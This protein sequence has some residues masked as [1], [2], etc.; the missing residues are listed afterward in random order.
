MA[1]ATAPQASEAAE[2]IDGTLVAGEVWHIVLRRPAKRNALTL[3]MFT[4]LA[5]SLA[6]ADAHPA[7]RAIALTGEG[8]GFCAGHDLQ[9]FAQWPQHTGDPVPRFL[10]ALAQVAKPLVVGVHGAAAGIGVTLLLHADWVIATP[11]AR[12]ALPFID[13]GI[14]PEAASTL[15]LARQVGTLRARQL[16]LG[17][18][19]FS[20][21]DAERWGLVTELAPAEA[22][23][24]R[25][26]ARAALLGAKDPVA[27]QRTKAWLAPDPARVHQR[28]DEE[29][30]AIN[31][32]LL[33][34]Q[35]AQAVAGVIA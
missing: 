21:E 14:A 1:S 34:R 19:P 25:V 12:L 10:H 18:E 20:S 11:G 16:L 9:A 27:Y 5:E 4:A 33:A 22:L 13:L 3:P 8:P 23:Q 15:L 17:G 32:A 24:A 6:I 2:A 31:Q 29:L 7:V 30:A 28:I 35:S 26:L